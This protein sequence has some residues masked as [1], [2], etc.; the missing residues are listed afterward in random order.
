[1]PAW[2]RWAHR[3]HRKTVLVD[4]HIGYVLGMNMGRE[5][6]AL[7]P[8]L[9]TWADAGARIEGPL[10]AQLVEA[11]EGSWREGR[12]DHDD[13]PP[14]PNPGRDH[15]APPTGAGLAIAV[16]NGGLGRAEVHRRYL[17]AIRSARQRIWLAHSYF[18][19]SRALQRALCQAVRRGVDVRVLVPD[20]WRNDV[21]AVSLATD[22]TIGKLLTRG[23]R[24]FAF[25]TRMMHAKFAV[26][27]DAW[28]TLGSANLDELSR[29]CNLEANVVGVGTS[30]A[31]QLSHYFEQL[32]GEAH[33]LT[34]ETWRR[35]PWWQKVLAHGAWHLRNW[36]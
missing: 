27:D 13:P 34:F 14:L 16:F 24:V 19:P 33:E 32:S 12:L 5:Y 22:H 8:G 1:V 18:L 7:W 35:R 15:D 10:V 2:S 17:H 6:F 36:L 23:V 3:D 29:T 30:E 21:L 9:R 28:W 20:L 31:E 11:F 25:D 26:V 4:G